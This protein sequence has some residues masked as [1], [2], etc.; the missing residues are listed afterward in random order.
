QEKIGKTLTPSYLQ[1][2]A[3]DTREGNFFFVPV[4]KQNLP[5]IVNAAGGAEDL[6]S[7][8]R[9]ARRR[10]HARRSTGPR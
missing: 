9:R 10:H 5:I 7:A 2:K 1:F 4:D 6:R 3:Y 8:D